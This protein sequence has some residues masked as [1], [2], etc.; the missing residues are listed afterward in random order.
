M[1]GVLPCLVCRE[2]LLSLTE[3]ANSSRT[4]VAGQFHIHKQNISVLTNDVLMQRAY[5]RVDIGRSD[6]GCVLD[7]LACN[8][9]TRRLCDSQKT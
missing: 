4:C 8:L 2:V 3:C 5:S 1:L 6:V 7:V 9:A